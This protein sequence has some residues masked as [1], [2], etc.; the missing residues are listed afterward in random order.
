MERILYIFGKENQ[1]FGYFQGFNELICVIYYI[2]VQGKNI[3]ETISL[4]IAEAFS[5]QMFCKLFLGTD[6]SKLYSTTS[7]S[8][9]LENCLKNFLTLLKKI[10]PDLYKVLQKFHIHPAT[11]VSRWMKVLFSQEHFF[12]KSS[13]YLGFNFCSFR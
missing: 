11:F 5:F 13:L 8:V 3:F 1:M 9:F 10:Y 6:F 2:M 7:N 4:D 12:T